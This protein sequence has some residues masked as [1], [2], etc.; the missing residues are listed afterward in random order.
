[1]KTFEMNADET[2]KQHISNADRLYDAMCGLGSIY[3]YY[4]EDARKM[5]MNHGKVTYK[6]K[7]VSKNCMK[8]KIDCFVSHF[9]QISWNIYTA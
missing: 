6:G 9:W 8:I 5:I 2:D 7:A 4:K 1:M 3:P